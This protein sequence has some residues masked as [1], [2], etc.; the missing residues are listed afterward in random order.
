MRN[1]YTAFDKFIIRRPRYDYDNQSLNLNQYI[2]QKSFQE[3]LYFASTSL[4]NEFL[5]Y[6]KGS[7]KGRDKERMEQ[8]L[9]KYLSRMM[10]RCTPFGGFSICGTGEYNECT[11]IKSNSEDI[12]TCIGIDCTEIENIRKEFIYTLSDKDLESIKIVVNE[13]I[14]IY[15]NICTMLCRDSTGNVHQSI[16]SNNRLLKFI[17]KRVNKKISISQLIELLFESFDIDITTLKNYVIDLII[18]GILIPNLNIEYLS[19]KPMKLLFETLSEFCHDNS[20]RHFF[21]S[22]QTKLNEIQSISLI[23]EKIVA[24][25]TLQKNL[26]ILGKTKKSEQLHLDSYLKKTIQIPST[27]QN[28]IMD[29]L[30]LTD[31][32]DSNYND[33]M[34]NFKQ[35]YKS[36]FEGKDMPLLSVLDEFTGIGFDITSTTKN[37]FTNLISKDQNTSRSSHNVF[38]GLSTFEKI[39]LDKFNKM[40]HDQTITNIRLTSSDFELARDNEQKNWISMPN[41]FSCM[42]KIIGNKNNIPILSDIQFIGPSAANMLTRFAIDNTSIRDIVA[43]ISEEEKSSDY[44]SAELYHIANT[45][46]GNVQRKPNDLRHYIIN[47]LSYPFEDSE[48]IINLRDLYISLINNEIILY[49]KKLNKR[50]M[51]YNTTAYNPNFHSSP[52]YRFFNAL[53]YQNNKSSISFSVNNLTN[54]FNYIP[55]ITFENI[56]LSPAIWIIHTKEIRKPNNSIDLDMF[57]NICKN[58]QMPRYLMYKNSDNFLVVDTES[59][60]QI[61]I[62]INEVKNMNII[63]LTEFLPLS[64]DFAHYSSIYEII[65][66]I[67]TSNND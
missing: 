52:I 7:L 43:F 66:P 13:T 2:N 8:T 23:E 49:S 37:I 12:E 26:K 22:L 59:R 1:K 39:I 55:R 9:L 15:P 48:Y 30:Y 11:N 17:I 29:L 4:Y 27:V 3:A 67:K 34:V 65:Q 46:Y 61:N 14:N 6:L 41:T 60:T 54:L 35:S 31:S 64:S 20:K 51:P 58:N 21:L 38:F 33:P 16:I 62:L 32:F 56:I 40:R 53:R 44:I 18:K 25:E 50:I 42:F 5:K 19:Y 45:K 28:S 10:F 63:K 24:I 57:I 36:R 47:Y